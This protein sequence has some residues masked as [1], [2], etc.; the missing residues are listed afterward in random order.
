MDIINPTHDSNRPFS[1]PTS[2]DTNQPSGGL[3]KY[4]TQIII[5]HEGR[6]S[7]F[8]PTSF[9]ST[10][11][12]NVRYFPFD[13]QEC[14]MKFGSW[15]FQMNDLDVVGDSN[16][17]VTNQLLRNAEW[18]LMSVKEE[19]N[20]NQ[21]ACCAFPFSD[22][23]IKLVIRRRPLFYIFNLMIPCFIIIAMVLM[24]FLLPPESGERTTLSIT[25]LLAMAVFL[26]LQAEHL[27]RNSEQ[28]PLLGIFYITVMAEVG[29]SLM[30]TCY[31]LNIFHK[32]PG[33]HIVPMSPLVSGFF[34][35]T[36]APL[37]RLSPLTPEWSSNDAERDR[38]TTRLNGLANPSALSDT[39]VHLLGETSERVEISETVRAVPGGIGRPI[40][41]IR[42]RYSPTKRPLSSSASASFIGAT[43]CSSPAP[44]VPHCCTVL[45]D[46]F[47]EQR[48]I[49]LDQERWRYL[50]LVLDRIFF[51]LFVITIFTSTVLI[52][53]QVKFEIWARNHWMVKTYWLLQLSFKTT[54]LTLHEK[55]QFYAGVFLLYN[56]RPQSKS[57]QETHSSFERDFSQ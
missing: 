32:N 57:G 18:D 13:R 3:S 55:L 31:V 15:T 23:T 1:F 10:C 35:E 45:A 54:S 14:I 33:V 51:I 36:M 40:R 50:A 9:I 37:L 30:A 16:P 4:H 43:D 19:R 8:T 44:K 17:I 56:L 34:I 7:W 38:P 47:K 28:I 48:L 5:D 41:S 12:L 42:P 24:G 49:R 11:K 39:Q 21:Y 6:H 2:A 25:V 29:L 46:K 52:Y 20:V 26:Q 53:S 27:P 22:L